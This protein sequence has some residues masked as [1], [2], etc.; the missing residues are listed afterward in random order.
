[1]TTILGDLG[2]FFAGLGLFFAGI[3][4]LWWISLNK[5]AGKN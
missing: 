1:M 5:P 4:V 3:G 2:V